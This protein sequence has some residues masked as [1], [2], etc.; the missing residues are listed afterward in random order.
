MTLHIDTNAYIVHTFVPV[1][2]PNLQ[3]WVK[4]MYM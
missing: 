2:D 3:M 1:G 4:S